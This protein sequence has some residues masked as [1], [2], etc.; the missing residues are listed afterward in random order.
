MS[1]IELFLK[2]LASALQ[3]IMLYSQ[4]HP[5]SEEAIDNIYK[6]LREILESSK[7][8]TI[9]FVGGELVY[10]KEVFFEL[11]KKLG[12]LTKNLEDKGIEKMIFKRGVSKEELRKYI[13][14]LVEKVESA[15]DFSNYFSHLALEHIEIGRIGISKE[16]KKIGI[17][18]EK[19]KDGKFNV[20][21]P[22]IYEN[23]LET[24][25]ESFKG[26]LRGES[27][28]FYDARR[29]IKSILDMVLGGRWDLLMLVSIKRHD[30]STFVH[31]L[32]VSVLAMVFASK[33]SLN[34]ENVLEIGIAGLFHD[35][36]KIAIS[37][38][39]IS[40]PGI[41]T[42]E[43]MRYIKSHTIL[44]A[45]ILLRYVDSL[46]MLPPVVA[47]E[48][49]LRYDLK[50]Y[51]KVHYSKRPHFISL[52][53]SLCDCYDA[54]RSRRSYKRYYPPEMIYEIMLKEKGGLFDPW[55]FEKF[56]GFL[57]VYP[58]STIVELDKGWV[59]IV[60]KQ[61]EDDIFSPEVEIVFPPSKKGELISLKTHPDIHIKSSL[62][63]LS[64]G[65]DYLPF[66]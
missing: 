63:P 33:L 34:K 56:F 40:K 65:K 11:S 36:G 15:E 39:V 38:R 41:L 8:I 54:L 2:E 45:E 66:L 32:N 18:K 16:K 57:G 13:G 12:V 7:D 52:M 10:D 51:P 43:E 64:S 50:G 6:I 60:R 47:F 37:Q 19:K 25:S 24:I 21:E 1:K 26:I 44:G 62:N 28:D 55:L 49:H 20:V 48:H 3:I 17:S 61:N 42:E 23:T 46:G 4:T 9:G 22:S 14:A 30:L 58:I 59:G 29:V 31:S 27:I 53:V 5:K 35:M